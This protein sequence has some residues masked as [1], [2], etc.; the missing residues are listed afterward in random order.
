MDGQYAKCRNRKL[1][2]WIYA[3]TMPI[4]HES[5]KKMIKTPEY[6]EFMSQHLL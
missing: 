5:T 4:E 6:H 2:P 1:K 3:W